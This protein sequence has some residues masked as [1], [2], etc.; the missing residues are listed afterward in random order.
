MSVAVGVGTG[1]AGRAGRRPVTAGPPPLPVNADVTWL[2]AYRPGYGSAGSMTNGVTDGDPL[3]PLAVLSGSAGTLSPA[4]TPAAR[5]YLALDNTQTYSVDLPNGMTARNTVVLLACRPTA[6]GDLFGFDGSDLRMNVAGQILNWG[7]AGGT[8]T[9]GTSATRQF[10][11]F[12]GWAAQAAFAMQGNTNQRGAGAATSPAADVLGSFL[13]KGHLDLVAVYIGVINDPVNYPAAYPIGGVGGTI[14]T[15]M[16]PVY[17]LIRADGPAAVTLRGNSIFAGVSGTHAQSIPGL[18]AAALPARRVSSLAV[19]GADTDNLNDHAVAQHDAAVLG[20]GDDWFTELTNDFLF[21]PT[22]AGNTALCLAEFYNQGIARQTSKP[23]T[24][25][26]CTSVLPRT[27]LGGGQAAFDAFRAAANA[28]LADRFAVPTAVPHYF[29]AADP[30]TAGYRGCYLWHLED[31]VL[32]DTAHPDH[33]TRQT[34][35]ARM[36]DIMDL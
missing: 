25:H 15:M 28:D 19:A 12:L 13:L 5:P 36:A 31:V 24:R 7:F 18:L 2:G 33:A 3:G 14:Q 21:G 1:V 29:L 26:H 9:A 20:A 8:D 10:S 35:A 6:D 22:N 4:G 17:P 30:G 27:G 16:A 34:F 11:V 32:E 23:G